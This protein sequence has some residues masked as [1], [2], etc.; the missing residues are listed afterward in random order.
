MQGEIICIKNKYVIN[1]VK[2]ILK[3]DPIIH[4]LLPGDIVTY[5]FNPITAKIKITKLESRKPIKAFG[6][7]NQ[8]KIV[9]PELPSI[10]FI[11]KSNFNVNLNQGQVLVI[12]INLLDYNLIGV[13]DPLDSTRLNDWKIVLDLYKPID[14][15]APTPKLTSNLETKP[16]YL[17][18]T[19][20]NT[21]NIDPTESKDFDDAISFDVSTNKIYIH[22][23]DA[24]FQIE[25]GSKIDKESLA[26]SFTLYLPEH[27]ENILPQELAENKLSLI[28]NQPRKTVTIEYTLDYET[29]EP[30]ETKIYLGI[31]KIKTRYDYSTFDKSKLEIEFVN[32]FIKANSS[33]FSSLV[34]P[35]LNLSINKLTGLVEKYQCD[36][37]P[38]STSHTLVQLL[39]ILTNQSISKLTSKSIPQR[40][41]S[42][43]LDPNLQIDNLTQSESINSILSIKK[44]RRAMY[45]NINSG[46]YGL[47]LS[48]YTHFTS[49]IRRYFDVIVHRLLQNCVYT[50]IEEILNYINMR[51]THIDQIVKLYNKIKILSLFESDLTKVWIGYIIS[52]SPSKIILEDLLFE[53]DC[54][55]I[56]LIQPLYSQVKIQIKS[57]DWIWLKPNF[58][59]I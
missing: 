37:S 49:P 43:S 55:P 16:D 46:H 20:L 19:Y 38:P 39:M 26:K 44:F 32:K 2:H 58:V 54:Y 51:E 27:I 50:N 33:K 18:L 1:G 12:Q 40:Y 14:S 8:D 6:V 41:H 59:L 5:T 57:I 25:P 35:V 53:I 3:Y 9:F 21:F 23:V 11:N 7:V 42:F 22:I 31:I 30:I 56:V 10:F 17:D 48:T 28:L 34:T 45:S 4:T 36:Y 13:Y 24:H 29:F 52:T 47:G 15:I